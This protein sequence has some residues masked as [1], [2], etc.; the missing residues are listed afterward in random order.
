MDRASDSGGPNIN[1]LVETGGSSSDAAGESFV[2]GT[3][4]CMTY[5]YS[6]ESPG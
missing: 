6:Y 2:P 1:L 5:N 3:R 4:A